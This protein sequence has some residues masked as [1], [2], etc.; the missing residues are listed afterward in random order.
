MIRGKNEINESMPSSKKEDEELFS[1]I[2]MLLGPKNLPS[3]LLEGSALNLPDLKGINA[4]PF[5]Q[6]IVNKILNTNK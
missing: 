1:K 2:K 5:H 3:D 4:P 6:G